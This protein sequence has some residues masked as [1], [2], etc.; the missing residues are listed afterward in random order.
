MMLLERE[1]GGELCSLV[2]GRVEKGDVLRCNQGV[3]V[4]G[5]RVKVRSYIWG[6]A[7]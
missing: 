1:W 5:G 3:G 2:G 6:E 4:L 7:D